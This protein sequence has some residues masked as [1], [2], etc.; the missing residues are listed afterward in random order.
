MIGIWPMNVQD[1]DLEYPWQRET[2][3]SGLMLHAPA[4]LAL[5]IETLRYQAAAATARIVPDMEGVCYDTQHGYGW[6]RLPLLQHYRADRI[7]LPALD[8][9]P[10]A[11]ELTA[12]QGWQVLGIHLD[13]QVP[14]A[15]LP[16]HWDD[17]AVHLDAMRLLIP[18]HV[19]EGAR[20]RV[21]HE[22]LF[23]PPGQGWTADFSLVHDV[24][25]LGTTDRISLVFDLAVTPEVTRLFPPELA[26][27]PQQRQRLASRTRDQLRQFWIAGGARK[28]YPVPFRQTV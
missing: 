10:A 14:G 23:Y 8:Q 24:W 26:A 1:R 27:D 17:Q 9:V 28:P 2:I 11:L 20:T 22:S 21:G 13:R 19:P 3:N 4:T 15:G 18:L 12:S 6:S 7:L 16:W 25:N 5:D